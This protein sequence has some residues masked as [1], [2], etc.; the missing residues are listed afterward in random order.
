MITTFPLSSVADV[1]R[2]VEAGVKLGH[3]A[4]LN[5]ALPGRG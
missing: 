3:Y 5:S 2:Q 1:H 4:L